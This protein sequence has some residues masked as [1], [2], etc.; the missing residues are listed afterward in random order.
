ME[1]LLYDL[2]QYA[3]E[4]LISRFLREY[5]PQYQEAEE[6]A[7]RLTELLKALPETEDLTKK[8]NFELDTVSLC[9]NQAFL[10]AGVSIGL[11]LGRLS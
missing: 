5:A 10:L 9:R 2:V 8:L 6:Q 3:E 4:N 11:N 1:T 7:A